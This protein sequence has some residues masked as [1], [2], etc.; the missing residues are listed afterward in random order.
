MSLVIVFI[1]V[2]TPLGIFSSFTSPEYIS[3]GLRIIF[4][5]VRVVFPPVRL[6]PITTLTS[7]SGTKSFGTLRSLRATMG[8]T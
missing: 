4:F 8:I 7:S 5:T 3:P 2:P 6:K 1:N